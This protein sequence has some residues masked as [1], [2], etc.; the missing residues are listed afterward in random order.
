MIYCPDCEAHLPGL[1]EFEG[2]GAAK[3]KC[4]RCGA[5]FRIMPGGTTVL[6]AANHIPT[7]GRGLDTLVAAASLGASSSV[8]PGA[9]NFSVGAAE[10]SAN[11]VVPNFSAGEHVGE[12]TIEKEVGRGATAVVYRATNQLGEAIALKVTGMVGGGDDAKER[13]DSWADQ[14]RAMQRMTDFRNVLRCFMPALVERDGI[15]YVLLP[16][17]IADHSLRQWLESRKGQT[18]ARRKEGMPLFAQICRGVKAVHEAGLVHLDLKPENVLLV[19]SDDESANSQP[20]PKIADFGLARGR[21]RGREL[22]SRLRKIGAG[23]PRYMAPEQILGARESEVGLGADIYALGV[24]LFEIIDGAPPF[25]GTTEE[26]KLKHREVSPPALKGVEPW[27]AELA[28]RCLDKDQA[29]RPASVEEILAVLVRDPAEQGAFDAALK[30]GEVEA[31]E[32]FLRRWPRSGLKSRVMTELEAAKSRAEAEAKRKQLPQSGAAWTN[33]LGMRFLPIRDLD[34]VLFGVHPVRV[35]D[36]EAFVADTGREVQRPYFSQDG[37]HPV[38]NVTWDDAGAFCDWLTW[39][40][41]EA[42]KMSAQ[43]QYRLASDIEWS[44]AVGLGA[45]RGRTPKERHNGVMGQYPWGTAWPPPK[46]CGNYFKSLGADNFDNTSP[47][48]AFAPNELGLVDMGGNVWEWCQDEYE[49]R[50]GKRVLRGGSWNYIVTD[51]LLSSSRLSDGT[52]VRRPNYGFRC[53]LEIRMT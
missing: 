45:E 13:L 8:S 19:D 32:D 51:F 9:L 40:E 15:S 26:L 23:T 39:K 50:S 16:L 18:A 43:Q 52:S 49:P 28:A 4:A 35:K 48:G 42:G 30:L 36:Y 21:S 46:G 12:F 14:Y 27:V 11:F 5:R 2:A 44:T 17:E 25:D 7:E 24:I 1:D 22:N 38:V 41:R 3:V 31:W 47:V 20:V 29:A 6:L 34:G 10:L 53:V 37:N 33:T